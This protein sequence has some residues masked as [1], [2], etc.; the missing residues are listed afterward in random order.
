MSEGVKPKQTGRP[1]LEEIPISAELQQELINL[2]ETGAPD[3]ILYALGG[4]EP[5]TWSVWKARTEPGFTSFFSKIER[6]RAIG[7]R[8]LLEAVRK[9]ATS[10]VDWKAAKYILS[11]RHPELSERRAALKA[12]AE[13]EA[14]RAAKAAT[15]A[16]T[17]EA[18]GDLSDAEWAHLAK[19]A[20]E[21]KRA[22][23]ARGKSPTEEVNAAFAAAVD[24]D[25]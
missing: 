25:G 22:S 21:L 13:E 1:R 10:G 15:Q 24:D 9:A 17:A 11:C 20:I 12:A 5:K 23:A 8:V 6:A 18:F 4:I 19:V 7:D 2:A 16:S 3:P 14:E